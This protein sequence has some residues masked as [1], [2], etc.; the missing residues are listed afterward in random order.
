MAPVLLRPGIGIRDPNIPGPAPLAF[1]SV[2]PGGSYK[3]TGEI[4][5]RPGNGLGGDI[6]VWLGAGASLTNSGTI[7]GGYSIDGALFADGGVGVVANSGGVIVNSGLI[8]GGNGASYGFINFNGSAYGGTAVQLAGGTLT[9]TGTLLGGTS[10]VMILNS[11]SGEINYGPGFAGGDGVY[12]DG[13]TLTNAGTIAGA[14]GPGP[15]GAA[16]V[17]GAY[18]S[19]VIVEAGAVFIGSVAANGLNDTLVLDAGGPGTLSGLGTQLTGF[20]TITVAAGGTWTLPDPLS[21]GAGVTLNDY[22]ALTASSGITVAGQ[23]LIGAAATL[24]ASVQVLAGGT[25]TVTGGATIDPAR[26]SAN[27]GGSRLVLTGSAAPIAIDG[28]GLASFVD[29]SH[30][31]VAA[32]ATVALTSGLA[33]SFVGGPNGTTLTVAGT[34]T[35][36]DSLINFGGETDVTSTGTVIGPVT[37]VGGVVTNAGTI[38]NNG[39]PAAV[40]IRQGTLVASGTIDGGA[41]AAVTFGQFSVDGP[42]TLV[43]QQGAQ[44]IGAVT[45]VT[46]NAALVLGDAT[47]GTLTGLGSQYTGLAALGVSQGSTWT[48]TGTQGLGAGATVTDEGMLTIGG[49]FTCPG[50]IHVT[51]TGKLDVTGAVTGDL[52]DDNVAVIAAGASLDGDVTVSSGGSFDVAGLV[53][54][55]V[56]T[57][58]NTTVETGG[59]MNGIATVA[60]G[61]YLAAAGT[62]AGAVNVSSGGSLDVLG[63]AAAILTT[64]GG[65]TIASGAR[66]V[67]TANVASGGTLD[68]AGAVMGNITTAGLATIETGGTLTGIA[69]VSA[70]GSLDVSGAITAAVNISGMATVEAAGRVTGNAMVNLGASL[71][72]AGTLTGNVTSVGSVTVGSGGTMAGTLSSMGPGSLDFA[73]ALNGRLSVNTFYPGAA[74]LRASAGITGVLSVGQQ[75]YLDDYGASITGS[76]QNLGYIRSATG[77]RFSGILSN[78]DGT[79]IGTISASG[80]AAGVDG[81][82]GITFTGASGGSNAGTVQ[83]GAGGN[84][85]GFTIRA[86]GRPGTGGMGV[87]YG[88]ATGTLLNSGTIVAGNGGDTNDIYTVILDLP[89]G[90]LAGSGGVGLALGSGA[91][92]VNGGGITG[93][94]GGGQATPYGFGGTG[95]IGV[96]ANGNGAVVDNR[97]RVTGGQGGTAGWPPPPPLVVGFLRTEAGNGG[98]GA[99]IGTGAMLINSGIIS[100]GDGGYLNIMFTTGFSGRGGDGGTGAVVGAGASLMN[101]GI[102][103]GGNAG[104]YTVFDFSPS[105]QLIGT[106]FYT[107]GFGVGVELSGGSLTTSGTIAAGGGSAAAL[108]CTDGRSVLTILPGASFTGAVQG[109]NLG[110]TLAVSNPSGAGGALTGLGTQFTGWNTLAFDRNWSMSGLASA[111]TGGQTITGFGAGNRITLTDYAASSASLSGTGVGLGNATSTLGLL[112]GDPGTAYTLAWKAD[113]T[114]TTL[115][116]ISYIG[117]A[118]IIAQT[119]GGGT[120]GGTAVNGTL[121]LGAIRAGSAAVNLGFA[122]G[123]GIAALLSGGLSATGGFAQSGFGAFSGLASGALAAGGTLTLSTGA[124]GV[125]T[126]TLVLAGTAA[127]AEGTAFL[128][129]ETLTVTGTVTGIAIGSTPGTYANAGGPATFLTTAGGL[130]AGSVITGGAAKA[131][132]L[133]LSGGGG[134][135][136]AAP[137]RLTNISRVLASEGSGSASQTV[138]LRGKLNVTVDVAAGSATDS[139]TLIGALD[140]SVFNLG[141]GT[142]TV[143]LGSKSETVNA[144][145]GMARINATA[146][147][148]GALIANSTVARTTL[149]VTGGG[150]AALNANDTNL[151]VVLGGG[152]S[153][154]LGTLGFIT[155]DAS[156]GSSTV[157]ANG[158]GQT[159]IAG[160]SDRLIG[161]VAGNDTFVGGLADLASTV[162]RN[163][164][165]GDVLDVGGLNAATLQPLSY[166]KGQLLLS[167]GSASGSVSIFGVTGTKLTAANFAVLGS[168]GHG[169]VLIGWHG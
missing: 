38:E 41:G 169:G 31:D 23:A 73:G 22:G 58:G 78:G 4:V 143:V 120:R 134:F 82:A 117:D 5:G 63:V 105:F 163:W 52:T 68:V 14:T 55:N 147:T 75:S 119:A 145:T 57:A 29:F 6:G 113:S 158:A 131:D 167:D 46:S 84:T 62:V 114:A 39:A 9:N 95:G 88:S 27:F 76:L 81:Y 106:N 89:R 111:F 7:A 26:I 137:T 136:L 90:L 112:T 141:A 116:G 80:G 121:D 20:S 3:N 97:S 19:T 91:T 108:T 153:L 87:D 142:D 21:I 37:V 66:L 157:F 162:I 47:D 139:I 99:S 65:A 127:V 83:G 28:L 54:G 93:G 25:L 165:T 16:V 79:G 72:L 156:A 146:T 159:L 160:P 101:S 77:L 18:A 109:N 74:S 12:L 51:T 122:A 70:G 104:Y 71:N 130:Q 11:D 118:G 125:F 161:A 53:I 155:V 98:A 32:D 126:E 168:D 149:T 92:L 96:V 154:R 67:G 59:G 34:L 49:S 100:G 48:L 135:N 85:G 166:A 140:R 124:L 24:D 2:E 15:A 8:R 36:A 150:K 103:R 60:S 138:T 64:Q 45:A 35:T 148:A 115:S 40:T 13:S 17:F 123:N 86:G 69:D 128:T 107:G 152:T 94:A 43:L 10:G 56:T 33:Q 129:P 102:I 1:L 144:G 133:L 50:S 44:I 164:T 30:I 61:G 151:T 132:W 42:G 110:A